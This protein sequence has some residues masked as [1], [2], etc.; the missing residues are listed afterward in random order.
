M[1][2][3]IPI[4]FGSSP[5][6]TP[7]RPLISGRA[8]VVPPPPYDP[9]TGVGA[10]GSPVGVMDG[11][12]PTAAY[13]SSRRLFTTWVSDFFHVTP[14]GVVA[15][16]IVD[17]IYDQSGNVRDLQNSFSANARPGVKCDVSPASWEYAHPAH[18]QMLWSAGPMSD[19]I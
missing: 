17:T 1:P 19:F 8:G 9:C 11:L 13:S 12:T 16:A 6:G 3:L 5:E 14:N 10:G 2:A 4:R 7:K 15:D 18:D